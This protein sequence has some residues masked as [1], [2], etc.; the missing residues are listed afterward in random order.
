MFTTAKTPM[1][2]V[3]PQNVSSREYLKKS[4]LALDEAV[5]PAPSRGER[6]RESQSRIRRGSYS[7]TLRATCLRGSRDFFDESFAPNREPWVD[8]S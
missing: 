4:A 8:A 2:S 3:F 7:L 5:L 1:V 6:V